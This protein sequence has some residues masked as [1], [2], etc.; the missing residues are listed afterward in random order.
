MELRRLT[1]FN[2][3]NYSQAEIDLDPSCNAFTGENGEGK[4][5]LLDAIH[6]LALCKSYFHRDAA[7]PFPAQR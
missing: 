4:T 3:K 1:L 6:Y 2:F 5:N 7:R